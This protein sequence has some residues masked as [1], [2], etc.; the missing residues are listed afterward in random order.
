MYILQGHYIG[1]DCEWTWQNAEAEYICTTQLKDEIFISLAKKG[2]C[3]FVPSIAM[4]KDVSFCNDIR[5]P[6][7]GHERMRENF[8]FLTGSCKNCCFPRW[9]VYS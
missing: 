3:S 2:V 8:L 1:L 5:Y 4:T 9:K 6:I 7:S